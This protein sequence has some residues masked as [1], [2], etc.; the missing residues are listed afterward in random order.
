MESRDLMDCGGQEVRLRPVASITV[1][2]IRSMMKKM[3]KK[4]SVGDIFDAPGTAISES[5]CRCVER[6][7]GMDGSCYG[8]EVM[9]KNAR[10]SVG[11]GRLRTSFCPAA[12]LDR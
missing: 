5:M 10:A 2:R 4:A 6:G 3:R 9:E 11:E 1:A 8:D 12:L 7:G